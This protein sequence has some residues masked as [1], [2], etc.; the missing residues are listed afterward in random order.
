MTIPTTIRSLLSLLRSILLRSDGGDAKISKHSQ[1]LFET[2]KRLLAEVVNEGLVDATIG[3]SKNNPYLYLHRRS[4]AME[5][6]RKWLKVGLQPGIMLETRDG[7]V[8][9]VVR[10]DSLQQPVV[11]SNGSGEEEELDPGILFQFLSP[12]LVEDADEDIL[13]EIALEL[14]NSARNQGKPYIPVRESLDTC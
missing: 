14:G 10:P 2:T 13:N 1:A 11:I 4:P 3:G 9:A 12:W 8:T 6:D 7:K 5:N